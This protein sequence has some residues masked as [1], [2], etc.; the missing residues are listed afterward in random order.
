VPI[1]LGSDPRKTPKNGKNRRKTS[2]F[3]SVRPCVTFSNRPLTPNRLSYRNGTDLFGSVSTSRFQWCPLHWG[4]TPKKH[5]FFVRPSRLYIRLLTPN[6]LSYRNGTDL[7][8]SVSTSRFQWCPLHWGQT[9]KKHHFFVRPSRLYIRLL[10]PN[11]LS[12]RNGTDLFGSVSTSRFRWCPL[13]WGQTP[14]KRRKTAK[15]AEKRH[16]SCPSVRVSRFLIGRWHQTVWATEMVQTFS[17]AYRRAGFD[18]AHYVG[19]RPPK[20]AEKRQKTPKK[21]IFSVC[22]FL[23]VFFC[24]FFSVCFFCLCLLSLYTCIILLL[25]CV[26]LG[27]ML[28]HHYIIWWNHNCTDD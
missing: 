18:G 12:Y 20:N 23:S 24:L 19:V 27:K 5:H 21:V 13:R 14:E 22:F 4:Q 2:F 26:V 8:G 6:C 3:L 28:S 25:H 1:T 9:P 11:C 10:T 16:F 17:E 7:F 15:T